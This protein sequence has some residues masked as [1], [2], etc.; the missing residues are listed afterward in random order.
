[1]TPTT[2]RCGPTRGL[3]GAMVSHTFQAQAEPMQRRG[4]VIAEI[5]LATAHDAA[6]RGAVCGAIRS[7]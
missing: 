2:M 1:M 3:G 4:C 7:A 6:A 5:D